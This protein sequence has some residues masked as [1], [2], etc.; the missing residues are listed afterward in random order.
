M[1][2]SIKGQRVTHIWDY[3]KCCSV[4]WPLCDSCLEVWE[5]EDNEEKIEKRGKPACKKCLK[6][7][8][9]A[10]KFYIDALKELQIE[11]DDIEWI[12]GIKN[13]RNG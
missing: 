6:E 4:R 12:E 10:M 2:G 7:C 11:N 13:A 5:S 9:K 1:I 8:A 3:D